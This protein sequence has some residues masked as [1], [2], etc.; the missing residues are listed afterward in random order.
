MQATAGLWKNKD[1]VENVLS[2]F[3]YFFCSMERIVVA[4][5]LSGFPLQLFTEWCKEKARSVCVEMDS[6]T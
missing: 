5:Y 4:F 6:D 1:T 3:I 2:I